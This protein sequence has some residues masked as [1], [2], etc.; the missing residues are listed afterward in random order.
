MLLHFCFRKMQYLIELESRQ[1]KNNYII[2]TNRYHYVVIFQPVRR[3][4]GLVPVVS[5]FDSGVSGPS[6]SSGRGHCVVFLG[7]T[8][9][10]DSASLHPGVQ[11]V[12]GKFN[13]GGVCVGDNPAM[14]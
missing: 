10:S 13:A 9:N 3:L 4:G 14:D 6:S 12:T 11:M 2:I 8:L 7:K 5:A 1:R